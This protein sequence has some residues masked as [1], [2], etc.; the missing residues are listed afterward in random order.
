MTSS[1]R[2]HLSAPGLIKTIYH[3]MAKVPDP[4]EF[5]KEGT[6]PIADHL[7]S[8]LAVFGLKCPS[9][10]DYDKK[11]KDDVLAQNLR[12]LYHVENVPSDSYLRERLDEFMISLY[13]KS[14]TGGQAYIR[15]T[16][17]ILPASNIK[18]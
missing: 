10:L 18:S 2:K 6:I 17:K 11:R 16:F 1:L 13:F 14:T 4:R 8:G 3:Q 5:T 15:K 9:L 12:D 7:M